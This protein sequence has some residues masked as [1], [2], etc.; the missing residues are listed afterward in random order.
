MDRKKGML[1]AFEGIDGTGKST[2]LLQLGRYL[3]EKGC[4]VVM[5]REPS[6]GPYGRKI[7]ELFVNRREVELAEELELF[8]KDRRLHVQE[9]IEPALRQDSI[10]LTDRY[11]F[12]TAAYQGAE[13]CD[14]EDIFKKNSFAPEPDAVF[15]LTIDPA[16]S[17]ERI[18]SLRGETPNDFEQEEKLARVAELFGSFS[19]PFI[20]RIDASGTLEE[21]QRA[22]RLEMDLLLQELKYTC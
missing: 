15:L 11:Y 4:R 2:Q 13:G 9:V 12:S 3:K 6:D 7:R 20:R 5:T 18:R 19:H 10:V 14:P 1:I 8:I 21:V 22:I 16:L 17:L